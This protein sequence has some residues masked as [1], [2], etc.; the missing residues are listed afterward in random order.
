MP[1]YDKVV[2]GDIFSYDE[3]KQKKEHY[4][5]KGKTFMNSFPPKKANLIKTHSIFYKKK[6]IAQVNMLF[7]N[8]DL[9]SLQIPDSNPFI[10]HLYKG[11]NSYLANSTHKLNDELHQVTLYLALFYSKDGIIPSKYLFIIF[12]ERALRVSFSPFLGGFSPLS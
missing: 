4:K 12:A 5:Q 8:L 9:V 6:Q 1:N 11:I 3:Y 7:L 10:W 2:M